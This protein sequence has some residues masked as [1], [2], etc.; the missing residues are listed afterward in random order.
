MADN[1]LG[2]LPYRFALFSG[3]RRGHGILEGLFTLFLLVG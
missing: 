1:P 2:C 3:D